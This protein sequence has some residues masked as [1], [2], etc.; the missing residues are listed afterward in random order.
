MVLAAKADGNRRAQR[1]QTGNV[2]S[3]QAVQSSSKSQAVRRLSVV[4][5]A[6]PQRQVTPAEVKQFPATPQL[7]LGLN[8]LIGVQQGSTVMTGSL[9]AAALV[10]YSWTVYL[11]KSIGRA[12]HELEGLKIS[13]QQVTTANE[14][15]KHSMAEQAE[16]PAAGLQPFEPKRTIFLVPA[17]ARSSVQQSNVDAEMS[18]PMPHPLG[19]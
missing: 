7:P 4:G 5:S 13:T 19:Y 18:T 1:S 9:V 2:V 8:L 10:I 3:L 11:D 14:T 12:F 6:A 15:L 16:S 17:P